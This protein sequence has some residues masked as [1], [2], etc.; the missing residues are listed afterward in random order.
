[1][2]ET[3]WLVQNKDNE[4]YIIGGSNPPERNSDGSWKLLHPGNAKVS[5][6]FSMFAM[7]GW[8]SIAVKKEVDK[9]PPMKP[10]DEPLEF[11][12]KVKCISYE[13]I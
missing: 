12:L 8:L 1:M 4:R 5:D 7:F 13:E 2:N 9:L 6:G 3:F 10:E 11:K